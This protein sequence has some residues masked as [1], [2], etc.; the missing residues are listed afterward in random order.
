MFDPS[1]T[2]DILGQMKGA[3]LT[4]GFGM[5]LLLLTETIDNH[6]LSV[7]DR[8]TLCHAIETLRLRS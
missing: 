3:V 2:T 1:W 7:Y 8:P 5:R 4:G 6:L